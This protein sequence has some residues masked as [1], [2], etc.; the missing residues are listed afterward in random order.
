MKAHEKDFESVGT[1]SPSLEDSPL[2]FVGAVPHEWLFSQVDAT[3]TH[4]GAGTTAA[5]LR[6]TPSLRLK[7]TLFIWA[8]LYISIIH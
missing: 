7:I 4:G 6:G 8:D 1:A 2:H 5:S 3:L